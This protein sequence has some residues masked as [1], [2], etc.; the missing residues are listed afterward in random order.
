MSLLSDA[1]GPASMVAP[2]WALLLCCGIAT[3]A[4]AEQ[5]LLPPPSQAD[6]ANRIRDQ[7]A[8]IALL[9]QRVAALE[10]RQP[11][12]PPATE[13][14]KNL[15]TT[16][17][18]QSRKAISKPP[19]PGETSISW[20]GGAPELTVPNGG[21]FHVRGRLWLDAATTTGSRFAKRNLSGTEVRS[22]RLGADGH[23]G[24]HL[25][26]KLELDFA[27]GV[28]TMKDVYLAYFGRIAGTDL[29]VYA[30]NK[31]GDRT[32]DGS[33]GDEFVPF[34]E[35]N[36][37][38]TAIGPEKGIFGMGV[39]AKLIGSDWHVGMNAVGDDANNNP[40]S[41]SDSVSFIARATFMPAVDRLTRVHFGAW[42]Y[43]E[44]LSGGVAALTKSIYPGTHFN[45]NLRIVA[46]P[47]ANP[48]SSSGEGAEFGLVRG[49][50]WSFGEYGQRRIR[51]VSE[52][53]TERSWVISGGFFITG[54]V[55]AFS[56]RTGN[57]QRLKPRTALFDGGI[58][59]IEVAARYEKTDLGLASVGGSG[60]DR[61]IDFNWY[62]SG[63]MKIMA[64]WVH[65]SVT[66]PTLPFEGSETGESFNIRLASSF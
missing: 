61:I 49:S 52:S 60:R 7:D 31:I 50:F 11:V 57:W 20:A 12:L 3:P 56:P 29:E 17:D 54:E 36:M 25:A 34:F 13:N 51:S 24:P 14:A 58:G 66:N 48:R 16:A 65:W 5:P 26:Y 42:G 30:G 33:S 35:R 55:P 40:G 59:A 53:R 9:L 18:G 6:M 39:L 10:A 41:A 43:R 44:N 32:I 1:V 8:T 15:A 37:L 27:D 19:E 28:A 38:A 62:L 46:L 64:D 22:A 21:T 47:I 2:G 23:I 63:N 45:D 4:Q